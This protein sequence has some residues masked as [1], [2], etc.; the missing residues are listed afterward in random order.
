M[1]LEGEI[2]VASTTPRRFLVIIDRRLGLVLRVIHARR[3]YRDMVI[4]DD[5]PV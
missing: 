2:S 4:D 1:K 5:I 3:G